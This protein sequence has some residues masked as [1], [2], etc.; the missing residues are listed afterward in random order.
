METTIT[1]EHIKEQL[2]DSKRPVGSVHSITGELQVLG[3]NGKLKTIE[4]NLTNRILV[5]N[6]FKYDALA[7]QVYFSVR[8]YY[9]SAGAVGVFIYR[10]KSKKTG[11][12]KSNGRRGRVLHIT[13]LNN[14]VNISRIYCLI[15]ELRLGTITIAQVDELVLN[16]KDNC[17]LDEALIDDNR[18]LWIN[19]Y[20]LVSQ[21]ANIKHG[22]LW[23][24]AYSWGLQ[25]KFSALDENFMNCISMANNKDQFIRLVYALDL[26]INNYL[27]C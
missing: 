7:D 2:K 11:S 25:L 16:H 19:D 9:V 5:D 23:N 4:N 15:K 8:D 24:K 18:P 10:P 14:K 20:E 26:N 17:G 6:N 22:E 27:N 1:L 13:E 21:C 3:V 12:N